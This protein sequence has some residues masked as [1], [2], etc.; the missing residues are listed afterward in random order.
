MAANG[1]AEEGSTTT[2]NRSQIRRIACLMPASLA[3][4]TSTPWRFRISK[5]RSPKPVLKPSASVTVGEGETARLVV[6][7]T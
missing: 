6:S 4:A 1:T 7:Y 3:S 2:F 5:L